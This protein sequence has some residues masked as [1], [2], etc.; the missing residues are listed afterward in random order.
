M[1]SHSSLAGTLPIL[2]QS[3]NVITREYRNTPVLSVIANWPCWILK[4]PA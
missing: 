4:A 1:H 3:A 2:L